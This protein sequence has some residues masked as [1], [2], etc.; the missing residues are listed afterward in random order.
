MQIIVKGMMC[1]HCENRVNKAVGALDG[2]FFVQANH[3]ENIVNVTFDENK[4]SL[5]DIKNAIV[6]Q[7][8]E[9]E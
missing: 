6:A 7:G 3:D 8:Y 9:I 5:Q 4:V 2:V 1:S